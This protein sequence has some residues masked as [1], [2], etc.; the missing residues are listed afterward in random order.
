MQ[1]LRISDFDLDNITY[2]VTEYIEIDTF[3]F[4]KDEN[5]PWIEIFILD[6]EQY[7]FLDEIDSSN[8]KDMEDLRKVAVKW[9]FDNV[10]IDHSL[11]DTEVNE[12]V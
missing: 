3:K 7:E 1:K 8:V 4:V 12:E 11:N 9:L 10:E 5:Y 2:G 6:G